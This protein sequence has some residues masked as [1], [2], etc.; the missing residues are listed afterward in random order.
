MKMINT[1]AWANTKYHKGKNI[2]A[3]IAIILTTLLIFLIL[4]I[5]LGIVNTQSYAVNQTYPTWH[6]MYRNASE[7]T[8]NEISQHANVETVGLR[9][10]IGQVTKDDNSILMLYTDQRGI[11]L[12]KFDINKGH[13]P[14]AGNEVVLSPHALK[15]LGYEDAKLGDTLKIPYQLIENDGLGLEKESEFTLAGFSADS[16]DGDKQ[17]SFV[18]LVSKDFLAQTVPKNKRE[19]RLM[20][21]LSPGVSSTTDTIREEAKEIGK[22][23]DVISDDIVVNTVYLVANYVDPSLYSGIAALIVVI[24][25]AG[26]LMI[27]SIYYVSLINKVQEFGKLKALGATKRQI[28]QAVL[29]ENLLV[30]LLAVPV[31]LIIGIFSVKTFFKFILSFVSDLNVSAR[32]MDEAV[33]SGKVTLIIPWVLLLTVAVAV[34]TVILS[35]LKPMRMA[36]K[37]SPIEAI[38]Y[39]GDLASSGKKREGYL[40]LNTRKLAQAN[41]SRNKK[42]TVLTIVSLGILGIL[43]VAVSTLFSSMNPKQVAKDQIG[44]DFEVVVE[45]WSGDEMNPDREWTAIQQNNPLTEEKLK[46]IS[47]VDGVERVTEHKSIDIAIPSLKYD[48]GEALE[49]S[50]LGGI[51]QEDIKKMQPYIR[52]GKVTWES[53]AKGNE[54]IATSY[55]ISH[56]PDVEVG[57]QFKV[58]FTAGDNTFTKSMT[59]AA[60]ADIPDRISNSSFV[61]SNEVIQS[62]SDN[63]L[64]YNVNIDVQEGKKKTAEEQIQD[65]IG[66]NEYLIFNSYDKVLKQNQSMT[67][68]ISSAGYGIVLVLALVG[69]MNLINTTVN[70][71]L[72]RKRELGI[73]QAIGMSNRQMEGMLQTEGMV[74]SLG[75][76]LTSV[77]FG[78]IVGYGLVGYCIENHVMNVK[79]HVYPV[80]QVVM[81]I[82]VVALVELI[83]TA[84]T[85]RMINKDMIIERIRI[86]E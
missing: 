15:A 28:R 54:M 13:L 45:A 69:V 56:F 47:Q 22:K 43:F 16:E 50:S 79:T 31:G 42:R 41:L 48:D 37:I 32:I 34:L 62:M 67:Q 63:N 19:Y 58:T 12:A 73:M 78:S 4:S 44:G 8:K 86:G 26:A 1:L 30:A 14:K 80:V 53:L 11:E 36:S 59:I 10:D 75:I 21:R 7:K 71:I 25:A 68:M 64:T 23:F 27:Y 49:S 52:E 29:R 3:G 39:T 38:R 9:H 40:S 33:K 20:L 65:I 76:I 17:K 24:A 57:S 77:I 46:Q 82:V 66:E 83:L 18:M 6:V 70:S 51:N 5:G 55:I 85:S 74:Y 84:V 81:L 61:T 60:L 2:L 35:T 72:N